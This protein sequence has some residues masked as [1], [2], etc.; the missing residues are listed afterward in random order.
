MHVSTLTAFIHYS[1]FMTTTLKQRSV[2]NSQQNQ[3]HEPRHQNACSSLSDKKKTAQPLQ[4]AP[5]LQQAKQVRSENIA[6]SRI[7]ID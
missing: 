7:I 1:L 5:F 3:Q 2:P 4:P 6:S